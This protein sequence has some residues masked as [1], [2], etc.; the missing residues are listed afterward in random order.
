SA[1]LIGVFSFF[2]SCILFPPLLC[3]KR[4]DKYPLRVKGRV[5]AP[6][7]SRPLLLPI[8]LQQYHSALHFAINI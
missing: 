5:S 3:E 6:P 4:A 7:I 8:S 2:S 1:A